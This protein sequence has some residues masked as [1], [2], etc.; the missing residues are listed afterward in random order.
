MSQKAR[1]ICFW[2][3]SSRFIVCISTSSSSSPKRGVSRTKESST[4]IS[5]SL[6]EGCNITRWTSLGLVMKFFASLAEAKGDG[7]GVASV[8]TSVSVSVSVSRPTPHCSSIPVLINSTSK[9][10]TTAALRADISFLPSSLSLSMLLKALRSRI[11]CR[12]APSFPCSCE[13]L[14]DGLGDDLVKPCS[15]ISAS[16]F[17]A[18]SSLKYTLQVSLQLRLSSSR[19]SLLSFFC[20]SLKANLKAEK[21]D[22]MATREAGVMGFRALTTTACSLLV[23]NLTSSVAL[24]PSSSSVSSG[25]SPMSR[26]LRKALALWASGGQPSSTFSRASTTDLADSSIEDSLI[27]IATPMKGWDFSPKSSWTS[28]KSR[29]PRAAWTALYLRMNCCT[30]L[31]A[32]IFSQTSLTC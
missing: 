28:F 32:L 23:K 5:L 22:D 10:A 11:R 8:S 12:F 20:H 15:V 18:S 31:A 2:M 17:N 1:S 24:A 30:F 14:T 6:L 9:S 3:P 25:Y 26:A 7:G 16:L 13:S 27:F 29:E 19:I 21:V 4:V